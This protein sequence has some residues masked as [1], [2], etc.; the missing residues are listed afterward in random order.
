MFSSVTVNVS[1]AFKAV[2]FGKNYRPEKFFRLCLLFFMNIS[3]TYYVE[4][5]NHSKLINPFVPSAPFFYPLKTSENRK[6]SWRFQ[7]VEKG[8]IGN[9]WVN[10][11]CFMSEFQGNWDF[12]H[13][14]QTILYHRSLNQ[15]MI[16]RTKL[17][18]L[19]HRRF[20]SCLQ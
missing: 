19:V 5:L 17:S 12:Q 13:F 15:K 14:H 18:S 2:P 7:G 10:V 4:T 11:I 9:K 3:D 6:V 16:C 1:R 8:C 20:P